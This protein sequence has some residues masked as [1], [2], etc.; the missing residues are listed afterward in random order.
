MRLFYLIHWGMEDDKILKVDYRAHLN[1]MAINV[2]DQSPVRQLLAIQQSYRIMSTRV[3]EQN[4]VYLKIIA[5]RKY[6]ESLPLGYSILDPE[7]GRNG[8]K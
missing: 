7:E 5:T 3:V 6:S 1:L 8:K 2:T 4:T